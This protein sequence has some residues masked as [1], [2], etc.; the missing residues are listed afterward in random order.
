MGLGIFL[1][2]YNSLGRKCEN[3]LGR[4][5]RRSCRLAAYILKVFVQTPTIPDDYRSP[6]PSRHTRL[7]YVCSRRV[8]VHKYCHLNHQGISSYKQGTLCTPSRRLTHHHPLLYQKD[9][10]TVN[11]WGDYIYSP[12]AHDN[13]SAVPSASNDTCLLNQRHPIIM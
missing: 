9:R 7:A 12:F 13:S 1:T 8:N 11:W 5:S 6:E 3:N 10:T 2:L 4:R